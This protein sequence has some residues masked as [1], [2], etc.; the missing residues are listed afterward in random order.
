MS[1]TELPNSHLEIK[2][3]FNVD[4]EESEFHT[5]GSTFIS[6]FNNRGFR[7]KTTILYFCI[8][9][10]L[11]FWT[12]YYLH[13]THGKHE[14]LKQWFRNY[15]YLG[16]G[17]DIFFTSLLLVCLVLL[18]FWYRLASSYIGFLV[19]GTILMSYAYLIGFILRIACKSSIDLDEEI[20]K[21]LV[22]LWCGGIGLL[23]AACLPSEKFN[24]N[25]GMSISIPIYLIML[26]LWR[27]VYKLDNPKY[28]V[29]LGYIVATT[30]YCWYINTCM[31]I[32]VT[33]RVH[34]Y[35]STDYVFAFAHL[36]TD[37]FA[38]F[39]VDLFRAKPT[40]IVDFQPMDDIEVSTTEICST[41]ERTR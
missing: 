3:S 21:L 40:K 15:D 31:K 5:T 26:L 35:K 9:A 39:W 27:F 6:E 34:K 19:M 16:C 25:I 33:K 18:S 14:N 37:I 24:S 4:L 12:F 13:D 36:Q 29:T 22:G 41:E 20:S 2:S 28:L 11:I 30:V 1:D 10:I 32:M 38:M 7:I 17:Y 23:I 8:H